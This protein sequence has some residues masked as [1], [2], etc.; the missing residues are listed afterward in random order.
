MNFSGGSDVSNQQQIEKKE[1]K[2][3]KK[4]GYGVGAKS[5]CL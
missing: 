5:D 3:K 4:K 1:R 2:K